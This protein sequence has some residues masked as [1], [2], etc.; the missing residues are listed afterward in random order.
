MCSH[1]LE[2]CGAVSSQ[3]KRGWILWLEP[4]AGETDAVQKFK[5]ECIAEVKG[6]CAP[7]CS[8]AG[9][10][11][12]HQRLQRWAQSAGKVVRVWHLRFESFKLLLSP[13]EAQARSTHPLSCQDSFSKV[14]LGAAVLV[15]VG[16]A[17]CWYP[18]G[19]RPSAVLLDQKNWPQTWDLV[20][21][22]QLV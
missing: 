12:W 19:L 6:K 15:F 2:L 4:V 5:C 18:T 16:G 14:W 22:K 7:D 3:G 13:R 21:L 17:N 1:F 9:L 20:I 10:V 11:R 8:Q